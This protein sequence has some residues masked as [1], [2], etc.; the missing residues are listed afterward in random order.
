VIQESCRFLK[1][2]KRNNIPIQFIEINLSPVQC[3]HPNLPQKI[4]Q[5][6]KKHNLMPQEL[7]FEITETAANRSPSIIKT[8]LDTL[9][10]AGF[11][12]AI[13]DFGTG[14][15]N[16]TQ[17]TD[18]PFSIVK[19]DRS[20]LEAMSRS[21]NGKLGLQGLVSM[22]KHINAKLVAE[23][24]ETAEQVEQTESMGIDYIQGYHFAKPLNP[25]AFKDY[26]TK[27]T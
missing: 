1:N 6:V 9:A 18:F 10:K 23:G 4:L 14:Y 15:S 19:F 3:L 20:L 21:E 17:L 11:L 24:V 5:I 22:F 2:L 13:D 12:I 7:C 25:D 8:N 26:L 16:I 27:E